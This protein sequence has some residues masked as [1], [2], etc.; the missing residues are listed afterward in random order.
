MPEVER[1]VEISFR[2]ASARG[3]VERP[4]R[5]SFHCSGN[6]QRTLALLG[7]DGDDT[8]QSVGAVQ[9]AL[10]TAQ[11]LDLG[12]IARQQLPEV[13]LPVGVARVADVNAIDEHLDVVGIR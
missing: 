5:S 7:G 13:K 2:P 12:E 4:E 6:F 9:A 1:V 8:A 10:R 3:L 11:N